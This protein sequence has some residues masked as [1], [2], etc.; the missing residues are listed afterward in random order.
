MQLHVRGRLVLPQVLTTRIS[1]ACNYYVLACVACQRPMGSVAVLT[2]EIHA[3]HSIC[4]SLYLI[5]RVD[6]VR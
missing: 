2:S 5:A 4:P 3:L 6:V 1:E